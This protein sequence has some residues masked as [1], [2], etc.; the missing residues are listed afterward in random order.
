MII[1]DVY[2]EK[3]GKIEEVWL[4]LNDPIPICS[5]GNERKRLCNCKSFELKYNPKT[6]ICSWSS[7]GYKTTQR[8]RY[9][10]KRD[11]KE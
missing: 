8:Y 9:V 10:S 3:C 7:E 11:M 5:C 1:Y 6:D 4:N 2:C